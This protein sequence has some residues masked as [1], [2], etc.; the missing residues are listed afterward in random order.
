MLFVL[1]AVVPY[2]YKHFPKTKSSSKQT[3]PSWNPVSIG[4]LPEISTLYSCK[5]IV[6][7]RL[8]V[9]H[10]Q[11]QKYSATSH[12]VETRTIMWSYHYHLID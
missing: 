11:M 10:I 9:N 1:E 6:T 4:L 12:M 2:T 8:L 7:Y 5:I 3:L